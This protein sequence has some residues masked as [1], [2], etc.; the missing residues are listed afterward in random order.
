MLTFQELSYCL[1]QI[2][3]LLPEL[4]EEH[5]WLTNTICPSLAKGNLIVFCLASLFNWF[6][7]MKLGRGVFFFGVYAFFPGKWVWSLLHGNCPVI[8][9]CFGLGMWDTAFCCFPQWKRLGKRWV[10]GCQLLTGVIRNCRAK[11]SELDVLCLGW[12]CNKNADQKNPPPLPFS[13]Y[14]LLLRQ[15]RHSVFGNRSTKLWTFSIW[16]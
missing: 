14:W 11:I 10:K 6:A 15:D 7:V 13:V 9:L 1:E 5:N 16:T 12:E 8:G 4:R 3:Y 2:T